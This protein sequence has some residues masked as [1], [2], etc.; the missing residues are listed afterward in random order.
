MLFFLIKTISWI[1]SQ[2]I[3]KHFP[4]YPDLVLSLREWARFSNPISMT[5][6]LLLLSWE[7]SLDP[8]FSAVLFRIIFLNPWFIWKLILA[9]SSDRPASSKNKRHVSCPHETE[10]LPF[11]LRVRLDLFFTKILDSNEE[12][13]RFL[14]KNHTVWSSARWQE[15]SSFSVR[16]ELVISSAD[17]LL[18]ASNSLLFTETSSLLAGICKNERIRMMFEFLQF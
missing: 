4:I 7:P 14:S 16:L 9:I 8:N 15:S 1:L 13:I 10:V 18:F 11:I 2:N 5:D 12:R 17:Y 3:V 6:G